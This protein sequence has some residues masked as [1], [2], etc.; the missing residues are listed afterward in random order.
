MSQRIGMVGIGLMG[1]G[2]ALNLMKHGHQV[3]TMAHRSRNLVED[4]LSRGAT[5]V[6]SPRAVA[7][8]S[9]VVLTCVTG[10]PAVEEIMFGETGVIAGCSEGMLV[11]DCSTG[12]PEVVCKVA[13]ALSSIG[14]D[15]ADAP[16]AR[17][18]VEAAAGKLNTMVG[19]TDETFARARPI[20]E[21]GS[22]DRRGYG[23]LQGHGC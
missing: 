14:V 21:S 2:I 18:P 1:H 16:L 6:G 19:A 23:R 15:F 7:E 12:L 13:D 9:D 20:L 17:T 11:I 5:E 22:A 8:A 4:L 10:A 3:V